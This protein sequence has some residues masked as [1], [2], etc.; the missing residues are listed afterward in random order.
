MVLSAVV[1]LCLALAPAAGL[2]GLGVCA[3]VTE[4]SVSF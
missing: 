4:I 3:E 2:S 1:R